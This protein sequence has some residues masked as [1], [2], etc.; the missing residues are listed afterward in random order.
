M[1]ANIKQLLVLTCD[2]IDN[3]MY[4]HSQDQLL[5]SVD[6]AIT[7][8]EFVRDNQ[9]LIDREVVGKVEVQREVVKRARE[10]AI[11]GAGAFW[12]V[13]KMFYDRFKDVQDI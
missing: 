6:I 9:A 5:K 1:A 11:F 8:S 4:L 10:T 2:N 7:I 12:G 13:E 3:A